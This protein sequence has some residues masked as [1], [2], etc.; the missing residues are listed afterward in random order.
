M[1]GA[2][3]WPDNFHISLFAAGIRH[4]IE[5]FVLDALGVEPFLGLT[6]PAAPRFD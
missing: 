6:A 1:T 4:D 5:C 2:S 3:P